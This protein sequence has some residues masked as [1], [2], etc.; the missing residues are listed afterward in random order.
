MGTA[1][2][3]ARPPTCCGHHGCAVSPQT[4]GSLAMSDACQAPP[5]AAQVKRQQ[6][7]RAL[8]MM[9]T[10]VCMSMQLGGHLLGL[11]LSHE[12][13]AQQQTGQRPQQS[14]S[15]PCSAQVSQ[16][17]PASTY[18]ISGTHTFSCHPARLTIAHLCPTKVVSAAA[19]RP[20][21]DAPSSCSNGAPATHTCNRMCLSAGPPAA[22]TH[23][24]DA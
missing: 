13:C 24:V 21:P 2:P 19:A 3:S 23:H 20:G 14:V 6:R 9:Y 11:L 15:R 7:G 18:S 4:T 8:P 1:A 17:I 10:S 5:R 12:A 22:L 16:H